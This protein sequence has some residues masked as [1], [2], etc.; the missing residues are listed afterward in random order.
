MVDV[1]IH[2][3]DPVV[4]RSPLVDN[5]ISMD[6][7]KTTSTP[8]PPT[9]QAQVKNVSKSDSSLKFGQRLSEL[10]KKVEAMPKK[11][12]TKKDQQRNNEMLKMINNMLLERQIIRS[13]E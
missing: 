9:T 7:K 10:E 13:L 3:E 4:Q 2:Q 12:W 5:V 6:T 11:A 1:P 8:T